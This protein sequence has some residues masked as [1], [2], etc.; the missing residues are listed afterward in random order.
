MKASAKWFAVGGSLLLIIGFLLP[1][2][3]ISN[4]DVRSS[5]SLLQIA[6]VS[7]WFFLY[8]VPLCAVVIL[9]LALIPANDQTT[10]YV[11]LAG[12][13]GGLIGAVL[14]LVG[15]LAYMVLQ[16]TQL[17]DPS[18]L[19]VLLDPRIQAQG[20]A[21]WP[22]IGFFI[23]LFG[24]GFTAFGILANL[25][26]AQKEPAE[27]TGRPADKQIPP[28]SPLP[29]SDDATSVAKEVYLEGK[30]GTR[31]GQKILIKGE[32]FSIGRS[33]DN[34]LQL[35]DKKISRLHVRIRHSQ[36]SWF[37]QDQNSKIG[38]QVNGKTVT[39]TRLNAGDSIKIG[40]DVFEFHSS[41]KDKYLPD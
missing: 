23:L 22:G 16:P 37:I 26:S 12:Q 27:V 40:E 15:T 8:L 13:V 36:D 30:K 31:V 5:I 29:P 10:K 25:P 20:G 3:S 41:Y 14:L 7:Y 38:T 39:A 18:N 11:F 35:S 17:T 32:N 9:L 34:D 6:G 2:I 28:E 21:I 24:F 33:R 19:G 4:A 1:V